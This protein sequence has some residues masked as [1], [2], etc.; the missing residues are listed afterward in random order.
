MLLFDE[1]DALFARRTDVRDS[2]DRHANTD[3]NY[4]LQ[5][6]EDFSGV[7]ILASNKKANLDPAF[8][9]RIRHILDFPRPDAAARRQIWRQILAELGSPLADLTLD[10]LA[11]LDLSGAQ[12]KNAILAALFVSRSETR[13]LAVQHVI[14]GLEREL[15]KD[16]RSLDLRERERL[17]SHG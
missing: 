7:A 13:P 8:T 12:I 5:L 14:R 6:V 15:E 9:R 1:A 16:G 4:L 10:S 11:A 17:A 2:H 3:T